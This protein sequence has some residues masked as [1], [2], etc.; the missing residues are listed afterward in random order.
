MNEPKTFRD[1]I[2]PTIASSIQAKRLRRKLT[3][4]ECRLWIRLKSKQLNSFHF[5][6]QAPL[7]PYIADF[8]CH[9]AR[10]VVEVDGRSHEGTQ[11]EHDRNRDQW[12]VEQGIRVIRFRASEIRDNLDSV[13]QRIR[14]IAAE[15]MRLREEYKE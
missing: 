7:G 15:Q 4:P 14:E 1:D 10:L 9:A 11:L 6:K 12:M 3:P 8:Y 2:K 5:R 13:L